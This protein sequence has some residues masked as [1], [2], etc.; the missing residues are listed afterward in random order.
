MM[1]EVVFLLFLALIV[2]G[3]KKTLEMGQTLGRMIAKFKHAASQLRSELQHQDQLKM[4]GGGLNEKNLLLKTIQ[5]LREDTDYS[6]EQFRDK[7]PVGSWLDICT[8]LEIQRRVLGPNHPDTARSTY[9][10]SCME[11]RLGKRVEA[12]SLLRESLDHGLPAWDVKDIAT[13]PDLQPLRGGPV[14]EKRRISI[15]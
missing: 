11:A 15:A 8:T 6:C 10:L 13:E 14:F 1:T 3:P 5:V 7:L 2:F 9:S 4:E 12:L